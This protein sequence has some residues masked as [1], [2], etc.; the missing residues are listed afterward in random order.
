MLWYVYSRTCNSKRNWKN[1]HNVV[2][3]DTSMVPVVCSRPPIVRLCHVLRSYSGTKMTYQYGIIQKNDRSQYSSH[4]YLHD[5]EMKWNGWRFR[6]FSVPGVVTDFH[7]THSPSCDLG[8]SETVIC[9]RIAL[10]AH[11]FKREGLI[12]QHVQPNRTVASVVISSI[13]PER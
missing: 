2:Y 6:V 11:T 10:I 1:A 4:S 8:I 13:R 7:Q 12:W 9:D 3:M 5:Y